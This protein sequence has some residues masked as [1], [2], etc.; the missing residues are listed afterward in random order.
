MKPA[1]VKTFDGGHVDYRF[2]SSFSHCGTCFILH[3]Y[4]ISLKKTKQT[5]LPTGLN[6]SKNILDNWLSRN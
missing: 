2:L 1:G 3:N 6:K 5:R 4:L